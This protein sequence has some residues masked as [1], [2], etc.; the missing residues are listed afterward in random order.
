[1]VNFC[2]LRLV[3]FFSQSDGGAAVRRH[4]RRGPD[5]GAPLLVQQDRAEV[6]PQGPVLAELGDDPGPEVQP[7]PE[8]RDLGQPLHGVLIELR[9]RP[10]APPLEGRG[11][12]AD[13]ETP[14]SRAPPHRHGFPFLP[15]TPPLPHYFRDL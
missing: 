13:K 14:P 5:R 15:I 8:G 7:V 10:R 12:P 6:V 2:V 1:M 3:C 4:K 11:A 9:Q